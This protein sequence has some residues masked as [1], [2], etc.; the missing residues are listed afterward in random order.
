MIPIRKNLRRDAEKT[1]IVSCPNC[2]RQHRRGTSGEYCSMTCYYS[3]L[4]RSGV[5]GGKHG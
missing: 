3:E 1:M 4:T 5:Y 2:H